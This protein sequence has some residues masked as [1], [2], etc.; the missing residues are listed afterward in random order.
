MLHV[1]V[2]CLVLLALQ[3]AIAQEKKKQSPVV[4]RMPFAEGERQTVWRGPGE[5]S[6]KDRFNR[7]AVDFSPLA[8]GHEIVS[9][10][11]GKVVFVKQDTPGPTGVWQDNNEVAVLMPNGKNVVVYLHLMKDGASVAVGDQLL[12]GDP[13]GRAGNTG[14][15]TATHLHIDVRIGHRL[16]PSVPWQFAV[17]K[18]KEIRTGMALRSENVRV[19]GLLKPVWTLGRAVELVRALDEP[20]LVASRVRKLAKQKTKGLPA[21]MAAQ[22]K[23]VLDAWHAEEQRYVDR[24]QN[25]KKPAERASLALILSD[26]FGNRAALTKASKNLPPTVLNAERQRARMRTR[27]MAP[28]KKALDQ[29]AK[30]FAA[31]GSPTDKKRKKL[32]AAFTKAC[33]GLA[34]EHA[35]LVRKHARTADQMA[36][37]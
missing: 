1:L 17:L 28:L 26:A 36:R 6:H 12:P 4:L 21:A 11:A 8:E 9:A 31:K 7:Y 37:Q 32:Q 2:P 18:G 25:A 24:L 13:I 10:T 14:N 19:R 29:E 3:P 33:K 16:G 34:A 35:D 27:A 22:Y 30:L 5:A 20:S 23:A 15:S